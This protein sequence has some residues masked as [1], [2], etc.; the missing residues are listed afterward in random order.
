MDRSIR[1]LSYLV[2]G[3]ALVVEGWLIFQAP[4]ALQ[5]KYLLSM[6]ILLSAVMATCGWMW[7][8]HISRRLARKNQATTLLLAIRDKEINCWKDKVYAYIEHLEEKDGSPLEE[9]DRSPLPLNEV[10]KLLGLYELLSIAVMN[11]TADEDMIKE[12]QRFVFL[13]LYQGL[14]SHIET[15]QDIEPGLYCHFV[16]YTK[17]W[18]EGALRFRPSYVKTDRDFL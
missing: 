5:S 14:K 10:E 11:G 4:D 13:R 16:H 18:N 17:K 9:R 2:F 8:G 7:S 15:R 3:T 1:P 6:T 12:S